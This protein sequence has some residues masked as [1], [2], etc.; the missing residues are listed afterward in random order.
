MAD[1]KDTSRSPLVGHNALTTVDNCR[2]VV[3]WMAFVGDNEGNEQSACG[4]ALV[5]HAVADALTHAEKQV[6]QERKP[7][8]E[9]VNG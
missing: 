1:R 8:L 4:R 7:R 6:T 5:L 2:D 3:R 9:V